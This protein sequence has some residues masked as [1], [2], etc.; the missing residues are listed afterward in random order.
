MPARLPGKT[1]SLPEATRARVDAVADMLVRERGGAHL[2]TVADLRE[3]LADTHGR[4]DRFFA[5]WQ[6]ARAADAQAPA[7]Q[8]Q[9]KPTPPAPTI[10]KL[11]PALPAAPR[12]RPRKALPDPG[13]SMVATAAQEVAEERLGRV[14]KRLGQGHADG[15]RRQAEAAARTDAA[16]NLSTAAGRLRA[17]L[18]GTGRPGAP[19]RRRVRPADHEGAVNPPFARAVAVFLCDRGRAARSRELFARFH[20]S[21]SYPLSEKAAHALVVSALAGSRIVMTGAEWWFK[22]EEKPRRAAGDSFEELFLEAAK[23]T[24][25]QAAGADLSAPEIEAAHGDAHLAVRQGYL[26]DALRREAARNAEERSRPTKKKGTAAA[27][28]VPEDGGI[29]KVGESYRWVQVR[30]RR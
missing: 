8:A 1:A 9:P 29:E 15:L 2:V 25:R 28:A 4:L 16:P 23:E 13:G 11:V 10:R 18:D 21:T 26:A 20:A 27:A 22:G 3:R 14:A 30:R 5:Q 17:A 24:L 12:G 6:A 19:E 7:H